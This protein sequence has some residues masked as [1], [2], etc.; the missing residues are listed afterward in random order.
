MF[1]IAID[2][3]AGSGKSTTARGVADALGFAHLD[4][5][6]M[7]RAVTLQAFQ[8]QVSPEDGPALANLARQMKISF[9]PCGEPMEGSQRVLVDG[10]DVTAEIREPLVSAAVSRVSAQSELRE[11]LVE[12]QR[13]YGKSAESVVAEGR[14]IGTVVFPEADLKVYLDASIDERARR[15]AAELQL[16]GVET[17]VEE[18]RLRISQRDETDSGR[19]ASPLREAS[20]AVNIDTTGLTIDEQ[21][22]RVT[23]L[24]RERMREKGGAG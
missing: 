15:R 20:D 5:G 12:K 16:S 9:Q 8:K 7:Y 18:Q 1:I 4:T 22:E 11:A 17:T 6:A 3:P 21:I 13:E 10:V 19:E 24:A 14:D 23:E 2:G